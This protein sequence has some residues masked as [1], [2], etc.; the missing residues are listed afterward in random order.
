MA[1]ADT[2]NMYDSISS[3][4]LPIT[5]HFGPLQFSV[6]EVSVRAAADYKH[7]K[8]LGMN[9][10]DRITCVSGE[11]QQPVHLLNAEIV[12]MNQVAR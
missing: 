12:K 2:K 8:Q 7:I 11:M 5:D 10:L 4:I 6:K 9:T 1:V 3:V